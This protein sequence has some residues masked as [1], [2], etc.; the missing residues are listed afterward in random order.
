MKVFIVTRTFIGWD[1]EELK[2]DS[3]FNTEEGARKRIKEMS[4]KYP[5]H[6]WDIEEFVV[7]KE[8]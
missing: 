1:G 4:D 7:N 2:I 8:D 3:V 5:E 6:F